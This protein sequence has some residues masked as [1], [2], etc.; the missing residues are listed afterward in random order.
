MISYVVEA[1]LGCDLEK[2]A[3]VVGLQGDLVRRFFEG[4]NAEFIVQEPQT[5]HGH[6]RFWP[7]AM[8]WSRFL[9]ICWSCAA[10]F[11]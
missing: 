10:I 7:A 6:T 9:G 11:R 4:S 1:A 5:R 3:I 2:I 8:S